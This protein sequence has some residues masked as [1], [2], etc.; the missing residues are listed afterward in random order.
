MEII[1]ILLLIVLNGIFAMAE[2][3]ILAARKSKLQK[4]ADEGDKKALTALELASHPN[5]FL[6]TV[7]IGITLVGVLAGAFGGATIAE[8]VAETL[9]KYPFLAPYSETIG[10]L[11]VVVI[12][13]Y[14]TLII[15]ELVPKR[16]ALSNPE[17]IAVGIAIPMNS[18]S[19]LSAPVVYFLGSST[20]LVLGF[21]GIKPPTEPSVS[22]EEVRMLIREGARVGVFNTFEKDIVERTLRLGDKKVKTLMTSRKEIAWLDIDSSFKKLRSKIAKN[23]HANF[24]VCSGQLDKVVGIVRT[25]DLLTNFLV[26]EK[27]DLRKFIHKPVF[28]PETMETLRVLELFK[29][30]GIHMALIVDEY[31]GI[32]GLISLTDILEEIVGDIPNINELEEKEIVARDDGTFLADGLVSVDEFKEFFKIKKLPG[33][34]SGSFLTVGGFVMNRLDRIPVT[35]DAFESSNYRFEVVDMDGN[36]VDKILVSKIKPSKKTDNK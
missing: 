17:K 36:R 3:A 20:D 10:I 1:I 23:P 14:L 6:S 18:L 34:K 8:A 13:T 32:L 28:V 2:I 11:L 30:S 9:S 16:L 35:G 22:E 5:R 12:I 33:E 7:Q 15:G 4:E 29:K 21:L 27:I 25:E 24:P 31:G 26:Q 19:R